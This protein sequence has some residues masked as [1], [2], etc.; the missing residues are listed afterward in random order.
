MK[1]AVSTSLLALA[2]LLGGGTAHAQSTPAGRAERQL[3]FS[4]ASQTVQRAFTCVTEGLNAGTDAVRNN[5]AIRC[6]REEFAP[7]AVVN[8]NGIP[9]QGIDQIIATFTGQGP[10][11][12]QFD[13]TI[14]EVHTIVDKRFDRGSL[15]R[16][17]QLDLRANV[18]TTFRNT[19]N[20]PVLPLDPGNFITQAAEDF[21]LTETE[22]GRWVINLVTVQLLSNIPIPPN[23][24]P[25]NFP[26]LP[27]IPRN[28]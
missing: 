7:N 16:K 1:H 4:E 3:A 20:T 25:A 23:S 14:Q 5:R 12:Q 27:S 17:A 11:A 24:F 10:A 8:F 6:L 15:T 2:L 13:N 18:V 28:R 22:P 19:L 26:A 21:T 9:I